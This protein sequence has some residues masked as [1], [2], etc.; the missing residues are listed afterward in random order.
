MTIERQHHLRKRSAEGDDP[1]T[2]DNLQKHDAG[3]A[4]GRLEGDTT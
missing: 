2:I 3:S 4:T 1:F